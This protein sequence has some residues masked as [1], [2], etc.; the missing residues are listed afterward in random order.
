MYDQLYE[1]IERFLNQLLCGFC[2]AHLT[3]HALFRLLQKWQK[4]LDSGEFIGT[5]L[6]DLPKAYDCLPPDLSIA[7]LEAYGLDNGSLKLLLDYFSFRK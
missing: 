2:K 1:Y 4:E 3:Q 6:M 5:I 7:K